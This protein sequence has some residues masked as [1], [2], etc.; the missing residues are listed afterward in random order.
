VE[1]E[2]EKERT[3]ETFS[4]AR[5]FLEKMFLREK[6]RR[7]REKL[8]QEVKQNQELKGS[9]RLRLLHSIYS[10]HCHATPRA[11]ASL[12]CL[13]LATDGEEIVR[14]LAY[15]LTKFNKFL[16]LNQQ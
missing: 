12:T 7:K 10:I 2:E 11:C 8:A 13:S 5:D 9:K 6:M 15:S 16:I 1:V 3:N 4:L 14:L